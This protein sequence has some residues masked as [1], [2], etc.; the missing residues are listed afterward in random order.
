MTQEAY[1]H[2]VLV[3]TLEQRDAGLRKRALV[4]TWG[5]V[6]LAVVIVVALIFISRRELLDVRARVGSE[7]RAL[8]Q[9]QQREQQA[10]AAL[11]AAERARDAAQ[12]ERDTAERDRSHAKQQADDFLAIIQHVPAK[13]VKAAEGKVTSLP[14]AAPTSARVYMQI[15]REEDRPRAKELGGS[16]SSKGFVVL[17]IE[18]VPKAKA[19]LKRTE[20]RFYKHTDAEEAA[21]I[22]G[23]LGD[24]GAQNVS[25]VDLKLDNDTR[26]QARHFEVWL[27]AQA[28]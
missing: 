13:E 5:S 14:A 6:L 12:A 19:S 22:G 8:A 25:V 27:P 7:T 11:S 20:V 17:G 4:I 9:L 28:N 18:N 1:L 2:D 10:Q 24:A 23:I 16:L 26:V 21:R 3:D 15:V